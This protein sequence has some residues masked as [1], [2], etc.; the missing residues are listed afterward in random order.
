MVLPSTEP[1]SIGAVVTAKVVLYTGISYHVAFLDH[2]VVQLQSFL[3]S[4]GQ[5]SQGFH[6]CAGILEVCA[7]RVVASS[8]T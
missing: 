4:Q 5:A 8:N 3:P 7:F 6:A 1:Q 2:I